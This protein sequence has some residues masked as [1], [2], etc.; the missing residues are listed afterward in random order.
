[1]IM[2]GVLTCIYADNEDGHLMNMSNSIIHTIIIVNNGTYMEFRLAVCGYI[3]LYPFWAV[4][5][6]SICRRHLT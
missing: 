6:V 2:I 1:M 4:I 3:T 5:N